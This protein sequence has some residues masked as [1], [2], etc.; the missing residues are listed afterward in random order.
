[1]LISFSSS[2][3]ICGINAKPSAT[4]VISLIPQNVTQSLQVTLDLRNEK[5][6]HIAILDHNQKREFVSIASLETVELPERT[7]FFFANFSEPILLD[8][9]TES[10]K[11]PS[12]IG[13]ANPNALGS[14]LLFPGSI[15]DNLENS[16]KLDQSPHAYE[17][18]SMCKS[19]DKLQLEE[20]KDKTYV[21]N[22]TLD[23]Y[24]QGNDGTKLK[25]TPHPLDGRLINHLDFSVNSYANRSKRVSIYLNP[26]VTV[27]PSSNHEMMVLLK[28]PNDYSGV[29]AL[30]NYVLKLNDNQTTKL[31]AIGSNNV[32][33]ESESKFSSEIIRFANETCSSNE[34]REKY[35][36][37]DSQRV[38]ELL[39]WSIK[40]KLSWV[41]S[42]CP[43]NINY[44]SL[45]ISIMQ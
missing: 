15:G 24:V 22:A 2:L 38:K 17:S 11:L 43:I 19:S 40:D 28:N 10:L 14:V 26:K 44:K 39:E 29:V 33:F 30:I 41:R 12:E 9:K 25:C 13:L 45:N 21:L 20:F 7:V 16:N 18:F 42:L 36:L 32:T 31:A 5:P 1:M 37:A 4:K 23:D 8:F 3:A 35:G 27:N 6:L 34:L